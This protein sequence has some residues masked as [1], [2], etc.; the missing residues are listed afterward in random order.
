MIVVCVV[1]KLGS[2]KDT[3]SEYLCKKYGFSPVSYSEIVHE[4]T[5]E[6]GL[7]TTR[8]NLQKIATEYRQTYGEEVFANMVVKKAISL[9]KDRVLLKEARTSV[10]VMPPKKAFGS[11]FHIIEVT[12]R[13]RLRFERLKARGGPKDTSVWDDFLSQEK[14]EGELGYF[15]A[16]EMAEFRVSNDGSPDELH[17]KL[18]IVMAKVI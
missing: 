9:G 17:K 15:G 8:A 3:A 10:D 5:R 2:G 7:E 14:R 12:T 11:N 1:G 18:D 4:K 13:Q 16:A 6:H